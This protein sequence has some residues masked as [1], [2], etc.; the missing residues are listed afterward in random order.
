MINVKFIKQIMLNALDVSLNVVYDVF[1]ELNKEV[2]ILWD[3]E[4]KS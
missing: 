1:N 3:I 2:I 4:S